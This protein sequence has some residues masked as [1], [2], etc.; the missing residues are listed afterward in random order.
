MVK[1]RDG[2]KA[3]SQEMAKDRDLWKGR[4]QEVARGILPVLN[5][6]DPSAGAEMPGVPP[7]GLIGKCQRAWG[8]FRGFVKEAGEHAGAHVLSMV[9]AHY[10]LIDLGRLEAGYPRGVSPDQ[11]EELRL[12]Q[13]DLSAKI[14]GDI[15]LCG[16]ATPSTSQP[17]MPSFSS[18]PTRPAVSTS[19]ASAGPSSSARA[20]PGSLIPG[21]S[22]GPSEQQRP[23]APT[24]Q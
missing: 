24:S 18:Q 4:C 6:I 16:D 14:I 22:V 13:M 8:W 5:F 1:D 23:R 2:W 11:A 17:G 3:Q 21:H 7:L 15:N 9:R 12:A 19:Q 10:P 20:V